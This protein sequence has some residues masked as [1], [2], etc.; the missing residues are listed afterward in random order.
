[1]RKMREQDCKLALVAEMM[2]NYMRA[3]NAALDTTL[4]NMEKIGNE[5]IDSMTARERRMKNSLGAMSRV[6][7]SMESTLKTLLPSRT[8]GYMIV[9]DVDE[10][11]H[12]FVGNYSEV[13][14]AAE[15]MIDLTTDEILG[16]EDSDS[17][18]TVWDGEVEDLE[19]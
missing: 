7:R 15:D 2:D 18:A 8:Q 5:V 14:P 13:L 11:P 1:M 12:V 17:D 4:K 3:E 9:H 19:M 6:I 10:I 16:G